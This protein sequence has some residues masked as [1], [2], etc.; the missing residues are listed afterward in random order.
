MKA[1]S[2]CPKIQFIVITV[3]IICFL[4]TSNT[5]YAKEII[6]IKEYTYHAGDADSKVS[7]RAIALEQVKRLLLE[8]LG[9]YLISETEVKDFK[10]SK[11]QITTLTA[12]I[13]MTEIVEEKWD[14]TTYYLKAR[15]AANPDEV[16]RA[17]SDIKNDREKTKGLE[18]AK[19]RADDALKEVE[20]LK[21]KIES[22]GTNSTLQTA[23]DKAINTLTSHEWFERGNAL[24][25][26][27]HY[28]EAIDA[29]DK[30]L[31]S[32]MTG[33]SPKNDAD[34]N[35]TSS[36]FIDP[37][38]VAN[39][40]IASGR[41]IDPDENA[42]IYIWRGVAYFSLGNYQQAIKDADTG[43]S[44][45]ILPTRG[46]MLRAEAYRILGDYQ[47][48]LKDFNKAIT[49]AP[50][51]ALAFSMR[52]LL[53]VNMSNF[54]QALIDCNKGIRMSPNDALSYIYRGIAYYNMAY[55]LEEK[56]L[57]GSAPDILQSMQ[58]DSQKSKIP[59]YSKYDS[60]NQKAIGD[61]DKAIQIDSKNVETYYNRGITNV[62]LGNYQQALSDLDMAIKMGPQKAEYYKARGLTWLHIGN[63]ELAIKDF[64]MAI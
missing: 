15:I 26:V 58:E 21:A 13:V 40:N 55:M 19:K 18:E 46:Y 39:T 25:Q 14:G 32:S 57:E 62:H 24:A 17:V 56:D 5:A 61:L 49:L 16:A 11:D 29:Y 51:Y 20:R 50:G 7:S 44:L 23:Y 43:I 63:G 10:I 33:P 12:G 60:Y 22:S 2:I 6:V 36:K 45:A 54:D 38:D 3:S 42:D 53:Y 48:A 30:A 37:D 47:H 4:I 35:K 41:F 64:D 52:C 1:N 27:G 28:K 9:T 31:E 59:R 34:T 8:E